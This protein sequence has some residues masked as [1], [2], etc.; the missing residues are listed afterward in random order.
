MVLS[1]KYLLMKNKQK[2]YKEEIDDLE[3]L[4]DLLALRSCL[5]LT[6]LGQ[7]LAP[8]CTWECCLVSAAAFS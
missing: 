8:A 5:F 7:A 4:I 1:Q 2:Y 6:F 3:I